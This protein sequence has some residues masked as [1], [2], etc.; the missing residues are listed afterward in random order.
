MASANPAATGTGTGAAG[1][2]DC[3][4]L[5]DVTL[6][7]LAENLKAR[8]A[9]DLPYTRIGNVILSVNPHKQLSGLY[10]DNYIDY[11][12]E[13][14]I[15]EVPPHIYSIA[16][17]AYRNMRDRNQDQ[18]V[19]ITGESGAGK[20]EASKIFMQYIAKVTGN[21]AQ[22]Q[23]INQKLLLASPV[24]ESFGNAKTKLN[25]N[26]SRFGKYTELEFNYRGQP[27]GGRITTYLLEKS[28]V[29]HHAD[30]ERSFHIF[31]QLL[32]APAAL[33]AT[34]KLEHDDPRA[35][36]FLREGEVTAAGV[37]DAAQFAALVSA[38]EKLGMPED[39]RTELFRCVAGIL[40]LGN[41]VFEDAAAAAE[42]AAAEGG[43]AATPVGSRIA[44]ASAKSLDHAAELLG[45]PRSG[46]EFSLTHR[47][48]RDKAAKGEDMVIPLTVAQAEQS[49]HA[50]ARA[51]YGRVFAWLVEWLNGRLSASKS[52]AAPGTRTRVIG[53]LDIF[54]FEIF[55]SNGLEQFS[56]N[57]ANEKLQQ[58][59]IELTLRGEQAEYEAE[60]IPWTFVEFAN[61][62]AI[63]DLIESRKGGIL[64]LLDEETNMVGDVTDAT[65]LAKLNRHVLANKHFDSREK[66]RN[67]KS[68]DHDSFRLRHYAG[69]V[70]YHTRGFLEKNRDA[71]LPDV[72]SC[73]GGSSL[74]L[75]H[76]LF[77]TAPGAAESFKRPESLVTQFRTSLAALVANMLA[78]TPHYI[79]CIKPN[80]NKRAGE[81]DPQLV[82]HQATYLGLLENIRCVRAGYCYRERLDKFLFRYKM[83]C[84]AT[85]PD[86]H[87]DVKDGI[88][89]ILE[90]FGIAPSE[91]AWGKTKI[92]IASPKTLHAL[93]LKRNEIKT[94]LATKIQATWRMH[95]QRRAY[96]AERRAIVTVQS[97]A[98]RWVL[99]RRYLRMRRAATNISRVARGHA[100]RRKF[101][102][103]QRTMPKYAVPYLQKWWRVRH[104]REY[105]KQVRVAERHQRTA[106]GK[107][108]HKVAIPKCPWNPRLGAALAKLYRSVEGTRYLRSLPPEQREMLEWK[109]V[110]GEILSEKEGYAASV[111][112]PFTWDPAVVTPAV[113]DTVARQEPGAEIAYA[114]VGNKIRRTDFKPSERLVVVTRKH[115]FLFPA[116]A[117]A[118]GAAGPT[119]ILV[120]AQIPLAHVTSIS[121]SPL[122]DGLVVLHCDPVREPKG[123]V[124]LRS[125]EHVVAVASLVWLLLRRA[126]RRVN[127]KVA[128]S[129][130]LTAHK[131]QIGMKFEHLARQPSEKSLGGGGA[132][133][134]GSRF[135]LRKHKSE[136]QVFVP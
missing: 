43:A 61:N 48:M 76:T 75:L 128:A 121:T 86:W 31:Y 37:D 38:L 40:H 110:A 22:V 78:K 87:G 47:T 105:L 16:D 130:A 42:P 14:G 5:H 69:N 84:P 29:N 4:L 102:R 26:S 101:A 104:R 95:V 92:F 36:A 24:L 94:R 132:D 30:G 1:V 53:V 112:R 117:A 7:A 88:V 10:T 41:L 51:I 77:G 115:L 68:L 27:V 19:L 89:K 134:G 90:A 124:I 74:P 135:S 52:T 45:V 54:G 131:K 125:E 123:D 73:L 3:V 9:A 83:L 57:Y 70:T 119:P 44:A 118:A 91:C 116:E 122:A 81:F 133:A 65:F 59:F 34:L 85:W 109:M 127:V 82:V 71:L 113:R 11:Y 97:L 12:R 39:Q 72:K 129:F 50:C 15:Y 103:L 33:R 67:D 107:P 93:E 66:T 28:R 49:R 98:R 120:K 21:S 46:L 64:A 60:G 62:Q 8:H 17:Q 99:R 96:L 13:K 106:E 18:C 80:A 126:G 136:V 2:D 63:V 114:F 20:T 55:P 32:R 100:A 79:R 6:E 111:P 58:L 35:Y 25:E 56:I 108:W 23:E